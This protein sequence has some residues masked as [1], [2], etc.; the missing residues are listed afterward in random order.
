MRTIS[1][2]D[3]HGYDDW[4]RI[5]PD[6]YDIIVFLGD[7]VDS[8]FVEDKEMLN[9]LDEIITFKKNNPEKVKLLLGNHEIS[10]L[11][12]KYRATGYRKLISEDIRT[13]FEQNA[14]LFQ[15]AFQYQ[16]FL[17][18]HAGIQSEFYSLHI[19]PQVKEKDECLAFTL[20]RLYQEK[21]SPI[22]EI[23]AERGGVTNAIGGP[24][25]LDANRIIENPLRG[26]HQIV[27]HTPVEF[28][29]RISPFENDTDTSVTLC[30]CIEYGNRKFYKLFL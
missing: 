16:N 30:D 5:R 29:Q 21:Y 3:V 14:E 8:F 19:K 13:R 23:G 11:F 7:Y 27:G 18:A 6:N 12:A 17:W 25:W 26:Y 1:I 4:K 15:V 22:F 20:Q 28:I 10:Y 24:F 2:G 9:N